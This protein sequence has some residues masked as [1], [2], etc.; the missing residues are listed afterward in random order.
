MGMEFHPG[1]PPDLHLLAFYSYYKALKGGGQRKQQVRLPWRAL[2][3][4]PL[5]QGVRGPEEAE[6]RPQCPLRGRGADI[7]AP[8]FFFP[9][10]SP[11][12]DRWVVV[13]HDEG[14]WSQKGHDS[15]P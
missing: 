1:F 7:M 9:P 10:P 15:P 12:L 8:R 4:E 5:R 13:V 6:W 3:C 2:V 14:G 11:R